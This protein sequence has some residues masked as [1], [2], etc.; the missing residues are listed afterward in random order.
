MKHSHIYQRLEAPSEQI[1]DMVLDTDTYNEID[2]QFALAYA[3]LASDRL[4]CQAVYAAPFHN[5]R[6]DSPADGMEKSYQEIRRVCQAIGREPID[7]CFRGSEL[8]LNSESDSAPSPA[9]DDLI[10]RALARPDDSP[11]Y[12]VAIGAPTNVASAITL[13]PRICEKIVVVWLGGHAQWFPNTAEFNCQQD[14]YASQILFDCGVPF[15]RIPCVGCADML[16]TTHAEMKDA[17]N[18]DN[19]ISQYLLKIFDEFVSHDKASS[20]VIWDISAI[21]WLINREFFSYHICSS[22]ILHADMT[23]SIDQRRHPIIECSRLN[24]DH[25][26]ADLFS[27]ISQV[28]ETVAT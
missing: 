20:K 12:V 14:Y 11:L 6:S 10:A 23:F 2:D 28:Q 25:I 15:V 22:P 19:T 4:N 26:F 16:L 27:R 24:R 17:G 8:W 1:V 7:G 21:A 5:E 18:Y 9:R 3:L 13:D